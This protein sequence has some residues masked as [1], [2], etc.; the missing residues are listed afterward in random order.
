MSL[1]RHALA[2]LIDPDR[3]DP[4][5]FQKTIELAEARGELRAFFGDLR[6]LR[7]CILCGRG[8][9]LLET[10][11]GL[12]CLGLELVDPRVQGIGRGVELLAQLGERFRCC[13]LA[14]EYRFDL[15]DRGLD[16]FERGRLGRL[17]L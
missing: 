9:E 11:L 5:L 14:A 3:E 17:A 6:A 1:L 10:L 4:R 8:A 15:V 12:V 13:V 7:R 2:Q 16:R